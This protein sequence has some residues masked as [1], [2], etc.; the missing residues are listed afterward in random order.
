MNAA[1]WRERYNITVDE[2]ERIDYCLKCF[3]G[4]ITEVENPPLNYEIIKLEFRK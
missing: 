1:Q 2:F 3:K 4:K